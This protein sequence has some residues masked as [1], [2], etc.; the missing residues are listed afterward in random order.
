MTQPVVVGSGPNG[1]AA[2]VTLAKAGGQLE[3]IEAADPPGGGPAGVT[4]CLRPQT[5]PMRLR[6]SLS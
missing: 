2:A 6:R 4:C 1:P 3:V 5:A